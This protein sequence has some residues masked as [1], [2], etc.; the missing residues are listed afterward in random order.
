MWAAALKTYEDES[1]RYTFFPEQLAAVPLE[2]V[3]A[4]LGKHR[5]AI[6]PNKHTHIWTTIAQTLHDYYD[7]DPR[8]ILGE[9]N[10]DAAQLIR[11]LQVEHRSRFPYLSGPKLSNYWPYILSHYTDATFANAQEIS[12]IPDTHVLQ[13]SAVLGVAPSGATPLEVEAAWKVLLKGSGIS[14]VQVHPVL[15]NWSRNNFRPSV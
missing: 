1:T 8:N 14:P 2:Q 5:L 15:W 13:S 9:A 3:R 4:D 11:L 12:I 6:Q 10:Y 7:N